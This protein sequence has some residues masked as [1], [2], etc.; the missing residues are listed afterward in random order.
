MKSVWGE[1]SRDEERTRQAWCNIL[2]LADCAVAI[3]HVVGSCGVAPHALG[4]QQMFSEIF[5]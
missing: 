2:F 3:L 5:T 4:V 1:F